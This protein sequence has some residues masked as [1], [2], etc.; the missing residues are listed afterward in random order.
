LCASVTKT[1]TGLYIGWI[2]SDYFAASHDSSQQ[3]GYDPR[4]IHILRNQGD[5]ITVPPLLRLALI[6]LLLS[7]ALLAEAQSRSSSKNDQ[8]PANYAFANYLGTGIYS[9]SGRDVTVINIPMTFEPEKQGEIV[10]RWRLAPSVGFYDF[11]FDTDD[12]GDAENIP[13]SVDTVS[14]VPGV[15]FD[16][17]ITD[18]LTLVPYFDLGWSKNFTSNEDVAI[19][20][21]GLSSMY[22]F[23]AQGKD[24]LWVSRLIYAGYRTQSANV[25]DSFASLQTGVDWKTPLRWG[26]SGRGSY[27]SIYGVTYWY[28]DQLSFRRPD[29]SSETVTSSYELGATYGFDKPIDLY[30]FELERVGFGY[31]WSDDLDIWRLTFNLPI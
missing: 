17:P 10:Y 9:T 15:E 25:T 28:F 3:A 24:H 29:E 21:V 30:L 1:G 18:D 7:P 22:D 20:S 16:F 13:D 4:H 12:I 19:Y 14:I 2:F 23:R 27:T 31:R 5:I 8:E 11:D 6:A 26:P